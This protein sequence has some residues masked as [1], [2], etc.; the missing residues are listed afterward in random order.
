[1][2]LDGFYGTTRLMDA[3]VYS[4][5]FAP[6]LSSTALSPDERMIMGQLASRLFDTHYQTELILSRLYYEG[7]N[8]VPSLGIAVPPELE[9]LKAVLGWCAAGVDARTERLNVLGF[10]MPGQM[11]V[12]DDLQGIWQDNNMDAES[13][14]V[15]EASLIYGRAFV[16]VG[17]N[18]D[19]TP[20]LTTESPENIYGSWDVRRRELSAA[21]QSYMDVDPASETYLSQ[22]ATLYTR[23]AIIQLVRGEKGWTVQ[24]RNDHNLGFVPVQMFAHK[25]RIHASTRIGT[26]VMNHAWRNTQDRAC[27]TLV[28]SE[29]AAEF[30]ATMKIFILGATE[31][32]FRTQDGSMASAFET[33]TG[34]LSVLSTDSQGQLPQIHEVKGDS[35]D[36][37]IS[38]LN[39]TTQVMAGHTGLP[40]QYLGIFSDGNPASADAIRMSDFR[41]KTTSDRLTTSF[42]NDWEAVM[43]MTMAVRDGAIPS[44]MSRIETDWAYTG[45][46]TPS[47]DAIVIATQI[48]AGQISPDSDDALAANGWTAVQ[49]AR[50]AKQREDYN[51]RVDA[52]ARQTARQAATSA[53]QAAQLRQAL[54]GQQPQALAALE[55]SRQEPT[56]G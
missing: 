22:L 26:S 27:R 6:E 55:T 45:I 33:Y 30:F 11:E 54:D 53:T 9:S 15:H 48:G 31:S 7:L 44:N 56:R 23:T 2:T 40:P 51:A 1:M 24:D 12:D 14:L 25:P 5:I 52:E 50:I 16:I 41:L 3:G 19:R 28:R 20:L 39:H 36:G 46:P 18:D 38:T 43:R 35:P 4:A 21:F 49:R 29:V 32:D 8:Q 42:G 13:V 17:V 34:R 37:F 47:A 10:R